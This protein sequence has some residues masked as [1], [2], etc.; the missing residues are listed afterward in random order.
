MYFFGKKICCPYF[1]MFAWKY[2]RK[3]WLPQRQIQWATYIGG[4]QFHVLINTH[5][6]GTFMGPPSTTNDFSSFH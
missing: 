3:L 1:D 6:N 5:L 4:L 2:S